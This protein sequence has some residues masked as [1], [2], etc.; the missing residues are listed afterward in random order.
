MDELL[1]NYEQELDID[2]DSDQL[3]SRNGCVIAQEVNLLKQ[4]SEQNMEVAM[5]KEQSLSHGEAIDQYM[6]TDSCIATMERI[7]EERLREINSIPAG[8]PERA[9]KIAQID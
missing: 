7:D 6:P 3:A 2:T 9:Q 1:G 8:D 4:A 5:K